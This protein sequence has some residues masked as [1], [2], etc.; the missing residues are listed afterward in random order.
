MVTGLRVNNFLR[1]LGEA[2]KGKI[3]FEA[4]NDEGGKGTGTDFR[5]SM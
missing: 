1:K 2:L 5:R 4:E 3:R